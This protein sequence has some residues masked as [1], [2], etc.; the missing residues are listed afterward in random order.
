MNWFERHLNKTVSLMW[1]AQVVLM[2][3]A[4]M[5]PFIPYV[6][7]WSSEEPTY[8]KYNSTMFWVVLFITLGFNLFVE[9]WAL[10]KK[11]RSLG[12]LFVVHIIP[13]PFGLFVFFQITDKSAEA[14]LRQQW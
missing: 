10:R 14:S 6:A 11:D 12:W 2:F 7:G 13:Y 8:E 9:R 3:I 1:F 5:V 4:T